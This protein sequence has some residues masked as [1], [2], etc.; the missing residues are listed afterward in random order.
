MK[1]V[2]FFAGI[3]GIRL[4]LERAGHKCIGFCEWDKFARQSYKAMYDTEGEWECHDIRTAKSYGLPKADLWTFGFPC[5]DLSVAGKRKGL[6]EGERSGLFYEIV[7]LLQ[8]LRQEDRPQWLLAENVKGLF[9]AGGG[10]DFLRC[11]LELGGLG[12]NIQYQLLNSKDF[13]VPQNRERVFIIGCLGEGSGR[14]VFPLGRTDCENTCTSEEQRP[15]RLGNIYGEDR[16]TGYAGNVWDKHSIAPTLTTMAG[17]NREPMIID[18]I[19]NNREPRVTEISPTLRADRQGLCVGGDIK[20]IGN[21]MPSGHSAGNVYDVTGIAPTVMENHG[22]ASAILIDK[23]GVRETEEACTLDACYYK[24]IGCNQART[25][26]LT[27]PVLAP[28]RG[29]KNQ[30][31]RRIKKDG[32]PMFTLTAQDRHG[33]AIER[34]EINGNAEERNTIEVLRVLRKEIGEEAFTQWGLAV[35]ASLQKTEVLQQRVYEEGFPCDWKK[36]KNIQQCS[37]N[38][39]VNERVDV[40]TKGLSN[41]WWNKEFG[42]SP[43]GREFQQQYSREFNCIVQKLP[44]ENTPPKSFMQSL[45][46]TSQGIRVLREALSKVQEVWQSFNELW[47]GNVRIRKLTPREVWRLQGF[48]DEYFDKAVAAGVS[49]SQLYKQAGNAVTVNVAEAI[50]KRLR[51]FELDGEG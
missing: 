27:K 46:Q 42:C 9:S 49:N 7:R 26:V 24:G 6:Q 15:I 3:G 35:I 2:D 8:G 47:Q 39:S 10:F 13:G 51:E 12:Y 25:G 38:C 43:Q 45:W 1:F 5:Q 40:K 16:G 14:E 21:Y 30:N 41:L 23:N 20:L 4:G 32:E 11:V 18:A 29:D 31:G 19:Y 48:P 17:G 33:V 37:H 34:G 44:Y 36:E 22:L 28:E 50:G